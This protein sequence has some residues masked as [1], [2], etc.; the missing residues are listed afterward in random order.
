M[1]PAVLVVSAVGL[2]AGVLLAI[3]SRFFHVEED[4]RVKQMRAC[5]PGINCGA[6]GFKGCRDYAKA[7]ARGECAPNLCI[8]GAA[9]VA[10]E[11]SEILGVR[12]EK[13][14]DL[15]AF[16]ACNGTQDATA[17]KATYQGINTCQGA[18]MLYGGP[19]TCLYGCIGLGDCA[20][21]CPSHA[22]CIRNGVARVDPTL[23]MG[24][25][26]CSRTC[27]KHVIVMVPQESR[28]VVLCSSHDKGAEARKSCGNACIGCKKCE[29]TCPIGAI[30]VTDQLARVDYERCNGCGL[31]VEACPTD[32][33]RSVCFP[34]RTE[35]YMG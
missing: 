23:C 34:V 10:K 18:A 16:V 5:L 29:K 30:T 17:K 31:C 27:P 35:A 14:K 20:E 24:C 3:V 19:N 33:L 7:L 8:P 1:L 32:C 21:A 28:T 15:L 6:C 26:L 11:L 13:P 25:G 2:L 4:E 22:I 9:A 12:V